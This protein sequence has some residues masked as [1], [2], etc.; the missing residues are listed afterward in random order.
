LGER[1]PNLKIPYGKQDI[2]DE[3]IAAVV[4]T[5][6]SQFLTQGPAVCDFEKD[7]AKKVGA[8]FAVAVNNATAGLHLAFKV[9]NKDPEKKVLVTPITFASSSNCV[10]FENGKVDFVDVHPQSFNMDLKALEEKLKKDP[11]GYQGVIVVDFAGQPVDTKALRKLVESYGLWIIEDACHA[12]GGNF[13]MSSGEEVIVGSSTYSDF[14]LFSFHPVKHIATGEGGMITTNDE[15]HYHQLLKLRSHGIVKEEARFERPCEGGWYHEMQ[16]LGFN[17]RM[18][19]INAAL[20]RSQ[21]K[22]L[23]QNIERRQSLARRYREELRDL[24]IKFQES[25]LAEGSQI[26][27]AYHLF[28]IQTERRKELYDNLKSHQI[29][30]QVHYIPVYRHPYYESLGFEK[31]LCPQAEHYYERALSLPLFHAMT[32]EEQSYVIEKIRSFFGLS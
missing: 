11:Q 25:D 12:I 16:E 22:R 20:G 28:V 13:Q 23:E 3:D 24:P 18:P 31:G 6:K 17:Y 30:T 32:D 4:E 19:D 29:F 1:R 8:R 5:L 26:S 15:E 2:Q 14:T 7:F 10:L 27:H 21:L 9:L